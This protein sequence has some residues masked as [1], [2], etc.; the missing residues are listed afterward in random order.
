MYP[1]LGRCA[2]LAWIFPSIKTNKATMKIPNHITD[3]IT[4]WISTITTKKQKKKLKEYQFFPI[5]W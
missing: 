5:Y 2:E 4:V 3:D 1:S